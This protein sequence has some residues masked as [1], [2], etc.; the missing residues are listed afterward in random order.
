MYPSQEA[1]YQSTAISSI[2]YMQSSSPLIA[3]GLMNGVVSFI[4]A[5]RGRSVR[6][7]INPS[8]FSHRMAC[9]GG[10][11]ER[12]RP[13]EASVSKLFPM[14]DGQLLTIGADRSAYLW[15]IA[16]MAF[17]MRSKALKGPTPLLGSHSPSYGV[18]GSEQSNVT[19]SLSISGLSDSAII[20][21]HTP[22]DCVVREHDEGYTLYCVSGRVL[23]HILNALLSSEDEL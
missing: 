16:P 2:C 11:F 23:T 5:R 1:A 8:S 10:F 12:F 7:L 21:R 15:S 19:L 22:L 13:H 9:S 14:R 20:E 3:T 18:I 6:P 4:D 17:Q